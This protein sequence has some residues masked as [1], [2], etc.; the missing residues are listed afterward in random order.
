MCDTRDR[1]AQTGSGWGKKFTA[2]VVQWS[3]NSYTWFQACS[4][5]IQLWI[6]HD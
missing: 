5:Y 1:N 6:M 3:K 4:Y 2:S